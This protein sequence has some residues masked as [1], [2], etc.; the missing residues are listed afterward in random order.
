MPN[1]KAFFES[2]KRPKPHACSNKFYPPKS[3][4][5]FY[6]QTF[7]S[8]SC[9]TSPFTNPADSFCDI[10]SALVP[11]QK[12]KTSTFNI[13]DY[14]TLKNGCEEED[15]KPFSP[16]QYP[17][18]CFA[19]KG[20]L[21]H[22]PRD[23]QF[24]EESLEHAS[25]LFADFE[26]TNKYGTL[27]THK[28]VALYRTPLKIEQKTQNDWKWVCSDLLRNFEDILYPF[29]SNEV[30]N[31]FLPENGGIEHKYSKI[32]ILIDKLGI[33]GPRFVAIDQVFIG[34]EK[35]DAR[36]SDLL[37]RLQGIEEAEERE[38]KQEQEQEQI[39]KDKDAKVLTEPATP[40]QTVDDT[41]EFL[42]EVENEED[43]ID[44]E[45]EI[46]QK[47]KELIDEPTET[48]PT[49]VINDDYDYYGVDQ[50]ASEMSE[51]D[52][53][54]DSDELDP[55]HLLSDVNTFDSTDY[56]V[57]APQEDKDA[58]EQAV[59]SIDEQQLDENITDETQND[60]N[61]D[62]TANQLENE[63][64]KEYTNYQEPED[65]AFIENN[66]DDPRNKFTWWNHHNSDNLNSKSD[67]EI[68]QEQNDF[69][70]TSAIVVLLCF[71]IFGFLNLVRKYD[72]PMPTYNSV[73]IIWSNIKPKFGVKKF[74][75]KLK[76]KV[77]SS[78]KYGFTDLIANTGR[79]REN[80]SDN[81]P[82]HL[83]KYLKKFA[84][85]SKDVFNTRKNFVQNKYD[86]FENEED[87]EDDIYPSGSLYNAPHLR[88][89][90]D[91][92]GEVLAGGSSAGASEPSNIAQ[93]AGSGEIFSRKNP[94]FN[95]E[96]VSVPKGPGDV[97]KNEGASGPG[98]TK[99]V[100]LK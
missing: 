4:K 68:H 64:F 13:F 27:K 51:P 19:Y 98:S 3:S 75:K 48:L 23:N 35:A 55:Y 28:K 57:V 56:Q 74:A 42:N 73:S 71:I 39:K 99:Y 33:E 30:S 25:F 34:S 36:R 82:K 31:D 37:R 16:H 65:V 53:I 41:N 24:L 2:P 83:K 32:S 81:V 85:S 87:I 40:V 97:P 77:T 50:E 29:E 67:T 86:N 88:A 60:I 18:L 66:N 11:L 21:L 1:K 5:V 12:N 52:Q 80:T 44:L 96:P 47:E 54:V 95:G 70:M 45:F 20:P 72:I 100:E 49:P 69:A 10:Y 61:F 63:N 26:Y 6:H 17:Y 9:P 7:E 58:S 92:Q 59:E 93:M 76:K 38:Q 91:S 90:I 43:P 8:D 78:P 22:V 79:M 46:E 84:K 15:L 14:K 94:H 62:Q 89:A